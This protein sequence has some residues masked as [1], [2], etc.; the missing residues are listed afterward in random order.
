MRV[1]YGDWIDC[2]PIL[3]I[4]QL[5]FYIVPQEEKQV[6][7]GLDIGSTT[8]KCAVLDEHDALIYSTYERHYSHILEKAQELLRRIDAEHLH[9]NKALL[10][11]SGSAGMGLADSCKVPFVQEVFSTR[12]A[13]KRFVPRTDCVIELG[14]E[15]A[16]ILFLT[17]GTEVRMNGSCAGGTGAFIDQM[18]TL[19]KMSADEMNKAAERPSAPIPS[20]PAAAC[21]PKATCSPSSIRARARRISPP[22]STRRWSTRPSRVWRR[23]G[24]SRATFC[25]WAG[26]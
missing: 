6:R 2:I 18:A 3:S 11:I 4:I 17:G 13:V 25:I 14:G 20:R 1:K 24:L 7:V 10:S 21:L 23:D 9:G 12:V 16:K 19:L 15:D 8:I 22:A 5:Y 26:R